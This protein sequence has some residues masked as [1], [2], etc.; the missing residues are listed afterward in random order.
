MAEQAVKSPTELT[1]SQKLQALA[2]K[3]YSGFKW[4]PKAG[5]YY[6][7][8]R[9]DLELYRVIDVTDTE[10]VTIYCDPNKIAPPARWPK[11]EFLSPDTFG[12]MR[13]FV[14]PCFLEGQS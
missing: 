1:E 13:V 2:L 10:V 7:T 6:T 9:A 8:C 3:Y 11:D 12:A 14:H 5:D 4:Q